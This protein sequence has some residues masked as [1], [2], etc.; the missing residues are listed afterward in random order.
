MSFVSTGSIATSVN[1]SLCLL[2]KHGSLSIGNFAAIENLL[3][4][5]SEI[6]S[7][8]LHDARGLAGERDVVAQF[9]GFKRP[10]WWPVVCHVCVGK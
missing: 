4:G 2:A 1:N 5:I 9:Q 10:V 6:A 3:N 8:L 7:L